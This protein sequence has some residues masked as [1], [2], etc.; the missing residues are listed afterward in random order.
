MAQ[1]EQ[2]AR[3]E[4]VDRAGRTVGARQT[5]AMA[6]VLERARLDMVASIRGSGMVAN[7]RVLDALT[8][9][10]REVFVPRFWSR[11]AVRGRGAGDDY[12]EW[13]V[14]VDDPRPEVAE[15]LYAKSRALA[16][17]GHPSADGA[18]VSGAV[19][20]T[21]SAP[22]LVGSMLELLELQPGHRVLEIGTG[23]GYNAALLCE[24]VGDPRL[25][26]SIDI[27]GSLVE[28]AHLRLDAAGYAGVNL[29]TGDGYAGV[30]ADVAFDRLVVTVGSADVAPA[31]VHQLAPGGFG[32]VPLQH[33]GTH[34][35]MRI[36]VPTNGS[37][38]E[39]RVIGRSAFVAIQGHQAGRSPWPRVVEIDQ[40]ADA[41]W[42]EIPAALALGPVGTGSE[43]R[44]GQPAWDLGY[45]VALADRDAADG[46]RTA[47]SLGRQGFMVSLSDGAGSL[48]AIDT[49]SDRLG[50]SGPA[51]PALADRL[52]ACLSEWIERG[53]PAWERYRHR[54]VP[55][56]VDPSD[57]PRHEWEIE[58]VDYCQL[59]SL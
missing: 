16:I 7:E 53:R 3:A 6:S 49:E 45:F 21:A 47:P 17:R 5:G 48:A 15:L 23:S 40:M 54:F 56:G 37:T 29:V 46:W 31:W 44:V 41:E 19:T 43:L 20:S 1:A 27:D 11:P 28:E 35:L 58:R 42:E 4:Q 18:T 36:S 57:L 9:V 2:M 8:K 50:R 39:G 22:E 13:T 30:A 33:G 24:L 32:I 34:P 26:T 10:P 52:Q 51:G 38:V 55:I 12:A 59:V 14:Q 25:V